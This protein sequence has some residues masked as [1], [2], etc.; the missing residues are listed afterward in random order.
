MKWTGYMMSAP[1]LSGRIS[2]TILRYRSL[3]FRA[4]VGLATGSALALFA[5]AAPVFAQK[6]DAPAVP[7][8]VAPD[9][10]DAPDIPG[11]PH[12]DP[13]SIARAAATPESKL[14]AD[15]VALIAQFAKHPGGV[16]NPPRYSPRQLQQRYGIKPSDTDPKISVAVTVKEGAKPAEI[17]AAGISSTMRAGNIVVAAEPVSGLRKLTLSPIVVKIDSLKGIPSSPPPR[18]DAPV[19]GTARGP[20]PVVTSFDHHSLTGRGVVIGV[21]DSGIDWHHGDF[22]DADGKSRIAAIWDQSDDTWTTSG[23]KIGTEPPFKD[24]DKPFGT[25][26]TNDQINDGLAGKLKLGTRDTEG[27]GTACAGTAA[28]NGFGTAK[29]VASG[30]Y[31]GV[32]PEAILLIVKTPEHNSSASYV[33][34]QIWMAAVAQD[35]KLPC[36]ISESFGTQDSP[37]D[38]SDAAEVATDELIRTSKPG[39]AV[40]VAA[41]N[42]AEQNMHAHAR[43]GPKREGQADVQSK[44]IELYVNDQT[45]VDGFFDAGDDWGL[46]IMGTLGL[47]QDADGKSTT[48]AVASLAGVLKS[49]IL[50]TPKDAASAQTLLD[51]IQIFPTADKKHIQVSISLPEGHYFLTGF[52]AGE[53]VGNGAFDLYLPF[54]N[55]AS[56]GYG[57]VKKAMVGSPGNGTSAITVGAYDSLAS[58]SNVDGKTTHFNLEL[59]GL[60][61]YSSPGYRRDDVVKPEIIAPGTYAI[62]T[63]A[64]G[65]MLSKDSEGK[66]DNANTTLDGKHIAWSGTSAAAPYTAGVVALMLQKNPKLTQA[67]IKAILIKTAKHDKFTGGTPNTEWGYGKLDPEAAILATPASTP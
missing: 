25:L 22:I 56:F 62:S 30:M 35:A 16:D 29:G 52:G 8:F 44:T 49:A 21:I 65:S 51:S 26:Y 18:G 60:S 23:G 48:L 57:A 3:A 2:L 37:H 20:E 54:A 27:H 47:L 46:G 4:G 19:V 59:G 31:A 6:N 14:S 66:P 9:M 24:G 50:G 45:E 33:S 17:K 13:A 7:A 43:F 63:L 55:T 11:A 5:A 1:A 64:G 34:G 67:K 58:W 61:E 53:H 39:L 32:A 42:E 36:V 40:V 10:T 41:G 38:G 15:L 12:L 28:G